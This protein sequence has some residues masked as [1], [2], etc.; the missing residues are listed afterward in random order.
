MTRYLDEV[1]DLH[2]LIEA[3]F[4]RGEGDV[5]SLIERFHPDFSMITTTGNHIDLSHLAQMFGNRIGT[6]PGLTIELSEFKTLAEWGDG[7]LVGYR[8]THHVKGG[9]S[10][11]RL[12]TALLLVREG[13]VLWRH[14]HETWSA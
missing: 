4:S 2:L 12:S 10:R 8:E 9:D 11:S 1:V 5:A 3:F 6:Q 14:L 7:S 13:R